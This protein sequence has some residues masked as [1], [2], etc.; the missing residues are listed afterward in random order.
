MLMD[1]ILRYTQNAYLI[2]LFY[3]VI[4][5]I[6]LRVCVYFIEKVV[7]RLTVKTKTD[8]DDLI[9]EKSSGPLTSII[10]LVG[11]KIAL[12]K[13]P[14]SESTINVINLLMN[15]L[16]AIII[17]YLVY[18]I[19]NI[20]FTRVMRG[21]A[22]KAKKEHNEGLI[23]LTKSTLQVV[24]IL[25][26][27]IYVLQMWG[28][29]VGTVLAGIGVAG[30]AIAFA[31]QESLSNIFGG[32]SI[33]LDKSVNVGDLVNLDDGTSGK[34]ARIGIRSTKI[35]TF[36]NEV[37]IVPN[38]KLAS[39]N[40]KNIAQP[41]PKS[42]VVIPFGVAYGTNI[43]KVKKIVLKEIKTVSGFIDDPEPNVRFL[44][45]GNSSLDFKAYFFVESYEQRFN[46]IDE[47][48]TKIYNAL[49]KNKIEIPF[50]QMDVHL[51]K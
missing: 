17:L 25:S 46:A 13:L 24:L 21:V 37:I 40:I 38:S 11:I 6:L 3:L 15:S 5:F 1:F 26:G 12:D 2:A 9:V 31:L 14:W 10:L 33:I 18:A 22:K 16:I 29:D 36:D 28:F 48:N 4:W 49:N 34:I 39:S 41:A 42:R 20:S 27:V 51:K 32:I 50:P 45:M 47:A 8:L 35:Q 43:E 44:A 7:L 23:Q 30:I 19:F